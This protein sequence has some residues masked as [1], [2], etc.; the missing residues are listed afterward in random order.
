MYASGENAVR[1][2]ATTYRVWADDPE[3]F[4]TY[5]ITALHHNFH[6]HPLF[7]VPELV[8]LA[9]ELAPR[10]QCRFMRQGITVASAITHDS[11]HPDGRS[12]E[13][14]FRRMEEPGSSIAL[15][16][17]EVIP[18]YQALLQSVV[19]SMRGLIERE[20]PDIFLVNG[21]VFFSAP[22]SVTPFHID[23]E[24]NFWLQ[25][26]GQKTMDVWDHRDRTIVPADGV[27]DFIVTQSLRKVRFK[28]EFM[29]RA[30][31]FNARPG[32][33]IYFPSTS[34]HMTRSGTDWVAPGNRLSISVGV[35]FYTSVT[36]KLARIHQTS[37]L[38]RKCGLSPSYP[39]ESAVADAYKAAVGGFIGA[40][41]ARF[42]GMTPKAR[43]FKRSLAPPPGSY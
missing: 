11:R 12:L 39:G 15:Y 28:E 38:M 7:Q 3:R 10:E 30:L 25:L 16:N 33:A 23:R 6:E 32:D 35:T 13:E 40:A 22:P 21:F 41:R 14:F 26:H 42:V 18:R 17:I 20:Q 36:R 9:M 37:R 1:A 31:E 24:N 29:S 34:P 8:K 27:E 5:G 4:S 43:R 19:G 2:P